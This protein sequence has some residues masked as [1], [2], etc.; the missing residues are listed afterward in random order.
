[1]AVP[2]EHTLCRLVRAKDWSAITKSPNAPAFK[3]IKDE[4]TSKRGISNWDRTEMVHCGHSIERLRTGNLQDYPH[5]TYLKAEDYSRAAE[6]AEQ[7]WKKPC[8]ISIR[9]TPNAVAPEQSRWAYAHVD[10]TEEETTET[11]LRFR[12]ILKKRAREIALCEACD[13]ILPRHKVDARSICGDCRE[14]D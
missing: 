5:T 9:Y 1:M 11:A 14:A 13:N 8:R 7:E 4:K 12:E 10:V 2:P 3:G 6:R